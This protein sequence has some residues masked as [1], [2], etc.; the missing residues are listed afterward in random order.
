MS[1]VDLL[2]AHFDKGGTLTVAEALTLLGIYALSQ[3]VGELERHGYPV[4]H[5][6]VTLPSGK[7]VCQ[8]SKLRV[9]YG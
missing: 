1:Q 4:D 9:A 5:Q 2:K 3:R 7:R 8:Y 6:M